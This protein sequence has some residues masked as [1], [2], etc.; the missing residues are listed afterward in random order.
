MAD[1]QARP[2]TAVK[3]IADRPHILV[4]DSDHRMRVRLRMLLEAAGCE[5]STAT[6]GQMAVT[7]LA[8]SARPPAL[9]LLDPST[10]LVAG[11]DFLTRIPVV[12]LQAA[13]GDHLDGAVALLAKRASDEEILDTVLRHSR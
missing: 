4:I 6:D 1:P 5:V 9:I 7:L 10:R 2:R 12:V 3:A 11:Q 13:P 8:A